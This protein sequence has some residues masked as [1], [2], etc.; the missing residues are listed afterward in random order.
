MIILT[1][2]LR[3]PQLNVEN[4]KCLFDVAVAFAVAV[5]AHHQK[6][7]WLVCMSGEPIGAIFDSGEYQRPIDGNQSRF[8]IFNHIVITNDANITCGLQV[9]ISLYFSRTKQDGVEAISKQNSNNV[10]LL[11]RT[12]LV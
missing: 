5:A 12:G 10:F 6:L 7:F 2:N 8:R 1:E 4:D 9:Q 11:T 3:L